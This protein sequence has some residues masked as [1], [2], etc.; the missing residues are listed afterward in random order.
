[1]AQT[2]ATDSQETTNE[3]FERWADD[4]TRW[5]QPEGVLT[6]EAAAAYGRQVLQ[7]AGVDVEAIE[8]SAG[9][10]RIGGDA[11]PKGIRSPR[12]NTAISTQADEGLQQLVKARGRS[13]SALVREAI[14]QYLLH[15]TA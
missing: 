3:A 10:P 2:D 11:A 13:R 4:P 1:M 7:D 5:K 12:V 14:D 6:G 9:R 15:E 8:R